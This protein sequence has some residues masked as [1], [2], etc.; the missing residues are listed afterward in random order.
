M[1][2]SSRI[3]SAAIPAVPDFV[4]SKTWAQTSPRIAGGGRARVMQRELAQRHVDR[5]DGADKVIAEDQGEVFGAP[6]AF[7]QRFL[8]VEKQRD[9]KRRGEKKIDREQQNSNGGAKPVRSGGRCG[10]CDLSRWPS[11]SW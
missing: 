6:L 2:F 7:V 1:P 9:G 11:S 3:D 4:A 5:I 8:A 10:M